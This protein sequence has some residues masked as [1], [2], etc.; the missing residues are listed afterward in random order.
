MH[1]KVE[2][3]D[4]ESSVVV[5]LE[6]SAPGSAGSYDPHNNVVST[7]TSICKFSFS[8]DSQLTGPTA[9]SCSSSSSSSCVYSSYPSEICLRR[10]RR[11]SAC[12]LLFTLLVCCASAVF[13]RLL[14]PLILANIT[15]SS[16]DKCTLRVYG[17]ME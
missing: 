2:Q 15:K 17:K 9:V 1:I 13:S 11:R 12:A 10:R 8:T 14:M 7:S 5:L 16:P 4:T 6:G 3:T